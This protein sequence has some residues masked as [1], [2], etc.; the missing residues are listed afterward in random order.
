MIESKGPKS[1]QNKADENL[2][3]KNP[4]VIF[5]ITEYYGNY[6]RIH[7]FETSLIWRRVR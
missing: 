1:C 6:Y 4:V 7:I 5:S 2:N 3:Y